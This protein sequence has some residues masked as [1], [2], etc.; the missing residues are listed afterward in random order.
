MTRHLHICRVCGLGVES[1]SVVRQ[2]V[3]L[4][5]LSRSSPSPCRCDAAQLPEQLLP[6]AAAA[7]VPEP[8]Q[9]QHGQD[10]QVRVATDGG[11][12]E[13]A[14]LGRSRANA[15]SGPQPWRHYGTFTLPEERGILAHLQT[16][17]EALF[18]A[19]PDPAMVP[20]PGPRRTAARAHAHRGRSVATCREVADGP[21]R[22]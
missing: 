15:S 4:A 17:S 11:G 12:G 21:N 13:L 10:A 14:G 22:F 1:K 2:G 20:P 3:P 16:L 18:G 19:A 5:R 7:S 6:A 8:A 9:H